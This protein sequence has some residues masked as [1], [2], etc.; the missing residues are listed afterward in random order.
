M[1]S[2]SAAHSVTRELKVAHCYRVVGVLGLTKGDL[3]C[4][5]RSISTDIP[6]GHDDDDKGNEVEKSR[7]GTSM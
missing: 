7:N 6:A 5:T 3:R 2:T 4:P 1:G